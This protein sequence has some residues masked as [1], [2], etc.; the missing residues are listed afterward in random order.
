MGGSQIRRTAR[1]TLLLLA[2]AAVVTAAVAAKLRPDSAADWVGVVSGT[3]GPPGLY[4]A[5]ASYRDDRAAE[6]PTLTL[7]EV[8]DQLAAVVRN[9]W[10]AEVEL[11]RLNDPYALPVRWEAAPADLVEDWATIERLATSGGAGWPSPPPAGA[12]GSGPQD[13]A[14][15]DGELV[16]VLGRI[17][18]GR[19]VVLGEPGAGK[20]ILLVRLVVDLLAE[21]RREPGGPVPVLLPLTSWDPTQQ[22]LDDWVESRLVTDYPFLAEAAPDTEGKT[23]ARRLWEAG[24]LLLLL[25]GLDEVHD[26]ARGIA[27]A[28]INEA[29]SVGQRLVLA[30]RTNSYRSALHPPDGVEVRLTGAAGIELLSLE[31]D[32]VADYLQVSAG[33]PASA[34]RWRQV[35]A[36]LTQTPAPPV[37]QALTTPL[38]ASLAR[39][40]Y[41]PRPGEP[42]ARVGRSPSELLDLVRFPTRTTVE[43]HLCDGYIPAAYRDASETSRWKVA[44]AERWLVFLARH[45]DGSPNFA[46]WNVSRDISIR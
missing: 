24:L 18:T 21:G 27:V 13:L 7:A 41:N 10:A 36:A 30:S 45:L 26:P 43:Q 16:N 34:A 9:Q 12:W 17:P 31:A 28:R 39:T 37:T 6:V 32:D 8:A 29:A 33:G 11:R 40:I 2:L 5:W 14:G 38:M 35:L 22:R 46:W 42:A 4:L 19:L 20:T 15:G 44:D 25:D 3:L 23:W 1:A